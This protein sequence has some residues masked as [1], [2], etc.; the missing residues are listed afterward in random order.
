SNYS[1]GND[2]TNGIYKLDGTRTRG[3][4][5][6]KW[7]PDATIGGHRA[8]LYYS[9]ATTERQYY[10]RPRFEICD[11][12]EATIQDILMGRDD[13]FH[14]SKDVN[15]VKTPDGLAVEEATTNLWSGNLIIYNDY[16]V[17]ASLTKLGET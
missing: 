13:A 14:P 10:L 7:A 1:G 6:F 11:G 5:D 17:P 8:Y 9:T 12:S 16:S 15:T 4:T 2:P 3:V